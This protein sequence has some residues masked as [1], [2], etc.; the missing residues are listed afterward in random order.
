MTTYPDLSSEGTKNVVSSFVI[1]TM[2]F[3]TTELIDHV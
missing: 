2:M 3:G 1:V